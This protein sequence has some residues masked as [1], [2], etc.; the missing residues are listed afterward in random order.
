MQ[1]QVGQ[2][3]G[4]EGLDL[5]RIERREPGPGE[6]ETEVEASGLNFRDVLNAMGMYPGDAG[7]LGSECAGTVA[8]V[9]SGVEGLSEGDAVVVRV[10]G[11]DDRGRLRLSIRAADG[12]DPARI[13]F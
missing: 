4:L 11:A 13:E 7:P 1:L 12:V 5:A 3:G 10:L 9:G 8:R 2:H 6:V